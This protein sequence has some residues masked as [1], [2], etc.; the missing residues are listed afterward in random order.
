VTSNKKQVKTQTID[1]NGLASFNTHPA[2]VHNHKDPRL[3]QLLDNSSS[4]NHSEKSLVES[5]LKRRLLT[6]TGDTG[7]E[8]VSTTNQGVS[9]LA[10]PE[11]KQKKVKLESNQEDNKL[12]VTFN[13]LENDSNETE[14]LEDSDDDYDTDIEPNVADWK[15]YHLLKEIGQGDE[16]VV[17]ALENDKGQQV[18]KK[19]LFDL[20]SHEALEELQSTINTINRLGSKYTINYLEAG[21]DSNKKLY[22]IME[23]GNTSIDNFFSSKKFQAL[24]PQARQKVIASVIKELFNALRDFRALSFYHK[25][26][27]F[28]NWVLTDNGKLKAID[29]D[30]YSYTD[31]EKKLNKPLEDFETIFSEIGILIH[32]GTLNAKNDLEG[33]FDHIS[34]QPEQLKKNVDLKVT[35]VWQNIRALD[36]KECFLTKQDL[37]QLLQ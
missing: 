17:Y 18:I 35:Q 25:D 30:G 33:I 8:Y 37:A 36:E 14:A 24:P 1:Q 5:S 4:L 2:L 26:P 23:K 29:L 12:L 13:L 22:V 32:N 3:P 6:F 16:G 21:I 11:E 34:L 31:S 9:F 20:P 7:S 19:E 15:G 27:T 28:K 10:Q